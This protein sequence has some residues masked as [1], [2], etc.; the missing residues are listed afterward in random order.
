MDVFTPVYAPDTGPRNENQS[1]EMQD[2]W[3]K[4][5]TLNTERPGKGTWVPLRAIVVRDDLVLRDRLNEEMVEH[6]ATIL[7][8]LPPITVQGRDVDDASYTRID[9]THRYAAAERVRDF[10]RVDF[11]DVPDDQLFLEAL[12][13][14]REHGIPLSMSERRRAVGRLLDA[15]A[16]LDEDDRMTDEQVART[17]GVSRKS[18][19][20]YRLEVEKRREEDRSQRERAAQAGAPAEARATPAVTPAADVLGQIGTRERGA[21][22]P[23]RSWLEKLED[24]LDGFDPSRTLSKSDPTTARA[25]LGRLMQL[26]GTL[27]NVIAAYEQYVAIRTPVAEE[28]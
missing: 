26:H 15:N 2:L 22:R 9:G 11:V 20:T 25:D 6:Y 5:D 1:P 4:A 21:P 7:D 23:R 8:A 24:A 13:A 12:R 14:N 16:G 10:I 17:A 3:Q 19:Y 27:T 18:V 28:A